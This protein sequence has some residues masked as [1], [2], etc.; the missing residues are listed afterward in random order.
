MSIGESVPR[1][2][3]FVF[4]FLNKVLPIVNRPVYFSPTRENVSHTF[5][6]DGII[7]NICFCLDKYSFKNKGLFPELSKIFPQTRLSAL[8]FQKNCSYVI[9]LIFLR[10]NNIFFLL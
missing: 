10:E 1:A 2:T 8:Q 9:I 5:I 7:K 4:V 3:I 6:F